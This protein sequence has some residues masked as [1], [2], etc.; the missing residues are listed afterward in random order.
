MPS[1]LDKQKRFFHCSSS[2][3]DCRLLPVKP[4]SPLEPPS[5]SDEADK[6]ST[7]ILADFTKVAVLF[8]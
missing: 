1:A 5:V 4:L 3:C 7:E 6:K 8:T 2:L